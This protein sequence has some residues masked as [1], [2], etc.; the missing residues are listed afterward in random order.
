MFLELEYGLFSLIESNN[1]SIKHEQMKS[2]VTDE[3]GFVSKVTAID[4]Y[5]PLC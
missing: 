4:F 3:I 1:F 2:L 5:M